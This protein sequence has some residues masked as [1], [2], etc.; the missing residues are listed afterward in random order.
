M[1][2]AVIEA[3]LE[4]GTRSSGVPYGKVNPFN[5]SGHVPYVVNQIA[6]PHIDGVNQM[7]EQQSLQTPR[8]VDAWLEKLDNF[9]SA[10]GG[11]VEKVR[12]DRAAGSVPPRILLEKTLPVLDAFLAGAPDAHPLVRALAERTEAGDMPF[13]APSSS[14]LP[15]GPQPL[16]L[17]QPLGVSSAGPA[18]AVRPASPWACLPLRYQPSRKL[19]ARPATRSV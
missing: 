9:P 16:P 5:F 14:S 4:A 1:Q 17:V 8:A 12:A 2:R 19:P 18:T 11:V 10:F 7:I 15:K 13:R 6:G 3:T